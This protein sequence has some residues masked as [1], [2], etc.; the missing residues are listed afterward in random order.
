MKY[1]LIKND[2][3]RLISSLPVCR[4]IFASYLSKNTFLQ[5]T[6]GENY[7]IVITSLDYSAYF[8]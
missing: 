1:K 3:R 6:L 2:I 5:S 7:N 8:Y 4:N